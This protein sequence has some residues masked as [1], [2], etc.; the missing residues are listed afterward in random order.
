MGNSQLIS[1]TKKL[2]YGDALLRKH[3]CG[4]KGKGV[5]VQPFTSAEEITLLLR[6][7]LNQP[8]NKEKLGKDMRLPRKDLWRTLVFFF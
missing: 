4:Q 5:A 7:L 1:I 2:K 6:D 8:S 3:C